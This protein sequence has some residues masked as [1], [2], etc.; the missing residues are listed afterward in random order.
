MRSKRT[1]GVVSSRVKW[2]DRIVKTWLG[3]CQGELSP[4]PGEGF[5]AAGLRSTLAWSPGH[6]LASLP[7]GPEGIPLRLSHCAALGCL[8]FLGIAPQLRGQ[9]AAR[10]AQGSE[11]PGAAGVHDAAND[12]GLDRAR[13]AAAARQWPQ[14]EKLLTGYLAQHEGTAATHTLL[15]LILLNE[16]RPNDSLKEFTRGAKLEYPSAE[17]FRYVA[18]D[19]ALLN[20]YADADRWM[21][22]AVELNGKQSESWYEL[23]RIR[24][25]EN[26]FADSVEAFHQALLIEPRLVKA[27]NNLGLALEGLNQQ[28]DALAAY[29]Q[30]IS[31]QRDDAHPSEQPWLNLGILLSDRD[32]QPGALAALT[33]AEAIAPHEPAIHAALGKLYRRG[34]QLDKAQAELEQAVAAKPGDA[35]L[36]FQLGEVYRREGRQAEARAQFAQVTALDQ[37]HSDAH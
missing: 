16:N 32:D 3:D 15:G 31:W 13:A 28:E 20:D 21:T 6:S 27:E 5:S 33:E 18:L 4:A 17:D 24:Y 29:R 37:T 22:K 9:A 1:S 30:A 10:G 2:V 36:H 7:N 25:M 35:S 19:Y 8:L 34:Q 12:D 26:R 23:G 11:P 14:A